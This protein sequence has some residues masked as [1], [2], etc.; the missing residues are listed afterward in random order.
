MSAATNGSVESSI[1]LPADLRNVQ[2]YLSKGKLIVLGGKNNP[3]ISYQSSMISR[4]Q[5]AMVIVYDVTNPKA[6]RLLNAYEYDGNIQESRLV[7][8]NRLVLVTSQYMTWGPV[9]MMR[10]KAMSSAETATIKPEDF[11]FKARDLLPTRTAMKPTSIVRKGVQTFRTA[12][13]TT[14]VDCTNVLYKKPDAQGK[15]YP[16][17]GQALTSVITFSLDAPNSTP[18]IKTIIGNSAQVH[19]TRN[20]LYVTAPSYV[21]TPMSCPL[22]ARCISPMRSQGN[23]TTIHQFSLPA[24][25][26]NY[27]TAVKGTIYSQ[28]N[29]DD[30]N[31]TLRIVTSDR[32]NNRNKTNVYT[33]NAQGKVLGALENIAPGEQSYGVRFID[34]LLYLVT[35]RQIDPLFVINLADAAKPVIMGQL[36]MPGYSTYLHPYGPMQNNI[37]YLIGLGYSTSMDE[38][39]NERQ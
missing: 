9:Y 11:S 29:M 10:D 25:G 3:Y 21:H 31:G 14:Q 28:Y 30:A 1:T 15:N 24:I 32:E 5:K 26:Y 2:L 7:D 19:V 16:M 20:T 22:N 17:R 12:K 37:Q 13:T 35:Y 18:A 39:G 27:S 36:K 6:P 33:V 34:N 38:R 4:D 23:Y 8:G